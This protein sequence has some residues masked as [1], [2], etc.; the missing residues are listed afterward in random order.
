[1]TQPP[2]PHSG[3]ADGE[4]HLMHPATP[5]LRSWQVIAVIL[6][7]IVQSLGNN[8]LTGEADFER[9]DVAGSWLAG[10]GAVFVLLMLLGVGL[11]FVVWRSTRFRVLDEALE[12]HSG[13]LVRRQRRARLDRMQAVDVVQP[14]LARLLGLARLTVE[15]AGGK[16]SNVALSY[17]R[18]DDARTLRNQL[19]A[20]AAGLRFE[21]PDAPEAPE[22][23]NLEVPVG[24]LIV[25]LLVSGPA[26]SF[27]LG[28]VVLGTISVVIG[29]P[30]PLFG[31]FAP[32]LGAAGVLWTRFTKGFGFR[33]ADSPD[34]LRLRYGLLEQRT[35][36]VPPGRV[37]AVRISQGLLW[38]RLDWW[39]VH[40]NIAGYGGEDKD[41]TSGSTLLPVGPK[42]EAVGVLALV[43]PDLGVGP[44]ENPWDVVD[45]GLRGSGPTAGFMTA[46]RRS[47]WVD[48]ISWGRSGVRVTDQALLIRSGRIYRHLDIVPHARTQSLGLSQGPLQ[49]KLRVASFTVHSTAGPVEAVAS[50]LDETEASALIA[51]QSL[52]ADQ[53]RKD[54]GPERWMETGPSEFV[55]EPGE[56]A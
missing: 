9:P 30:G 4:W 53:A 55:Q 22:R 19:L 34:G 50:H 32:L 40:V 47:R 14:F 33:V 2:V 13:I 1:M 5:L 44:G 10:A 52:R 21:G 12:L 36:T 29:H 42:T 54:S 25:S 35:Q 16:E 39:T 23:G 49:R 46:P 56:P 41:S 28:V 27:V 7:F 31:S 11:A 8:V 20:S 18:E 48:P 45:A 38:R 26:I 15:V 37:Q 3:L 51:V 24:R 6:V 17:L 43:L